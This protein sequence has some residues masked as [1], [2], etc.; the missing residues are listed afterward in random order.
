MSQDQQWTSQKIELSPS[1]FFQTLILRVHVDVESLSQHNKV[2]QNDR[3]GVN[4]LCNSFLRQAYERIVVGLFM[5]MVCVGQQ[6][7]DVYFIKIVLLVLDVEN[8]MVMFNRL[9]LT[10]E[11][12]K[13]R[14][15]SFLC[16]ILWCQKLFMSVRLFRQV[17]LQD[18]SIYES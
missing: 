5:Q 3:C 18:T 15:S 12:D 9:V 13:W 8:D 10:R 6:M 16:E 7:D 11:I 2:E 4:F 1:L 17:A 14:F